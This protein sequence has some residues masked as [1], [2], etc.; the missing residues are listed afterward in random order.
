MSDAQETWTLPELAKV[1]GK[2]RQTLWDWYKAGKIKGYQFGENGTVSIP[3][4]E[5]ER[6]IKIT[7]V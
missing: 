1:L 3:N 7:Q 4:E 2:S 6:L 5:A